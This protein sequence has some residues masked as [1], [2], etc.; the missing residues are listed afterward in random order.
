LPNVF[1]SFG[2]TTF[3]VIESVSDAILD[4]ILQM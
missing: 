4:F 1:V 3:V 2:N